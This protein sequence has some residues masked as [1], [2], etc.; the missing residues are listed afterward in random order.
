LLCFSL[1]HVIFSSFLM[2]WAIIIHLTA[3]VPPGSVY[4]C[5]SPGAHA[6]L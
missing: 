3:V 1:K 5:V 4:E 6:H 2:A